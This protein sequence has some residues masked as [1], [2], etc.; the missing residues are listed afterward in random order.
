MLGNNIKEMEEVK[1]TEVVNADAAKY[2]YQL[3]NDEYKK[4][5]KKTD[6]V[7]TVKQ[8]KSYLSKMVNNDYTAEIHYNYSGGKSFGRLFADR[9]VQSL[10]K[11]VRGSLL[12]GIATDIDITNAHPNILKYICDKCNIQ[13]PNLSYYVQNRDTI[14]SAMVDEVGVSR[15]Q[16]KEYFLKS[17]ND[18]KVIK[19]QFEF[20]RDYDKELKKIQKKLMTVKE[21]GFVLPYSETKERNQQGSFINNVMCYY[22]NLIL[23]DTVDFMKD[24]NIEILGLFFDGLMVY[25]THTEDLLTQLN[26]CIYDKWNYDFKFVFKS[27]DTLNIPQ[28]FNFKNIL[29]NYET[30]KNE[31]N[32]YMAKVGGMYVNT[33][34]NQV[35][36]SQELKDAFLHIGYDNGDGERKVFINSWITN[37]TDD[38]TVYDK[39]GIYPKKGICPCNEYNLWSKFTYEGITDDYQKDTV[40]LN[41]I[42]NHIDILCNHQKEVYDFNLMW[43]AQMVQYPEHKSMCIIYK[44]GEG[45]GK[46]TFISLM[47]AILGK[48]KL[49]ETAKPDKDVWGDFNGKMKDAF[50]VHLTE[51]DYKRCAD[52]SSI[53]NLITDE[54]V[55]INEKGKNQYTVDSYHRFLGSTNSDYPIFDTSGGRRFLLI[56]C[57]D[58][59]KGDIDY[60]NTLRK[61]THCP[62]VQ[63]TFYD[64]LMEYPTKPIISETDIPKTEFH[65]K[66]RE[67]SKDTM[68]SFI[69]DVVTNNYNQTEVKISSNEIWDLFRMFCLDNNC[70]CKMTKQQFSTRIGI[71]KING[72]NNLGK[73]WYKSRVDRVWSLNIPQ[74]KQ[75]F[76]IVPP[77]EFIDIE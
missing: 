45:T 29:K 47:G 7:G 1:F 18:C 8:I 51:I 57:S 60:F 49:F 33:I 30:V 71:R 2:L 54:T 6:I 52:K 40:G 13:C 9:G 28:D 67:A 73:I 35:Y 63:R 75:H 50:L 76:G 53:Y 42:L 56:E 12:N 65:T 23:N 5:L 44:S 25:G 26:Q 77:V 58:E 4:F 34:T 19:T 66:I 16:A 69:E 24:K 38:M 70:E 22:E 17:T 20:L 55:T 31:F 62:I 64:F 72:L 15:D 68:D 37:I 21:Y 14:L 39:F 32:Q 36:K 61:C 27:H 46:N 41:T 59:K 43:L 3:K 10:P 11:I 74:L 48:N